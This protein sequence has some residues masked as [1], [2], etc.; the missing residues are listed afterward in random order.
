VRPAGPRAPLRL[1]ETSARRAAAFAES[2]DFVDTIGLSL[3]CDHQVIDGAPGARFLQ[4]LRRKIEHVES[5][6]E[7]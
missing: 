1:R 6:C 3:T 7:I 5:I 2:V 4:L